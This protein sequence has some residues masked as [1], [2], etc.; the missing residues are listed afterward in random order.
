[1]SPFS[2]GTPCAPAQTLRY[3]VADL[4]SETGQ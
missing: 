1:M 2:L 4:R 3:G